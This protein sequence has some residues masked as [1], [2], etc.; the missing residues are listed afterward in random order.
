MGKTKTLVRY[1]Q[2]VAL[3]GEQQ[4]KYDDIGSPEALVSWV[5]DELWEGH[6][7]AREEFWA[8]AVSIRLTPLAVMQIAAGD[9]EST[10]ISVRQV[11]Q[12]ALLSNASGLVVLHNHPS[13]SVE[14]SPEDL[15]FTEALAKAC[16]LMNITLHDHV[17]V[18]S[19]LL[20]S[21]KR[22]GL[23]CLRRGLKR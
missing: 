4:R 6:M 21:L 19:G 10:T 16:E 23:A 9:I 18:A 3:V 14:P 17:I 8:V 20:C 22:R 13:G 2:R 12:M 1:Y 7:P 15:Q 5:R 11:L